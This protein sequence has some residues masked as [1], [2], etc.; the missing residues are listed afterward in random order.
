MAMTEQ[1]HLQAADKDAALPVALIVDD[2]PDVRDVAATLFEILGYRTL[3][4]SNGAEALA[5]LAATPAVA[6]LFSD[7]I[8]PGMNGLLLARAAQR[9]CPQL[10]ILLTTGFPFDKLGDLSGINCE[11]DILPKPYRF[12]DLSAI[13]S[14]PRK[15][16]P[17]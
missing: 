3:M 4:A 9:Q 8:M 6:V 14:S 10:R 12:A 16:F 2:D 7:L 11:F 5:L 13:L 1:P 15:P 17:S